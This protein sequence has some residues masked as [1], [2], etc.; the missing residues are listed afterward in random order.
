M[1]A[2]PPRNKVS[3]IFTK[4][5]AGIGGM[6]GV[7]WGLFTYL[8]PDPSVFGLNVEFV[9]WKTLIAVVSVLTLLAALGICI[10]AAK[11]PNVLKLGVWL[12]LTLILCAVFFK[13]GGEYAKPSFEFARAQK[14]TVE[15]AGSNVFGKRTETI[16]DVRIEL[17][18][19]D[20]NGQSP[21]CTMEL[22]NK[23]ADREFRFLNPLSLFEE[24]GGA[25]SLIQLRVGDAKYDRW[26]NFQLIRNVPTR[27]TLTFEA[28]KGRVK[29]SPALKLMF[30][31]RDGKENVLKFTD[32]KVS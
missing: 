24:T 31:D 19:C 11:L 18:D 1:D 21:T 9:N 14:L 17:L 13:L 28:A 7:L 4:I 27:V 25:L 10:L 2:A 16:D 8:F 6:L 30:R 12:S 5:S 26:D 23:G 22:L 3:T 29:T 32:V 15:N 20:Q